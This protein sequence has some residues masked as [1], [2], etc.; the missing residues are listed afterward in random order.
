MVNIID[1]F[2]ARNFIQIDFAEIQTQLS[3]MSDILEYIKTNTNSITTSSISSKSTVGF[4][5]GDF[6]KEIICDLLIGWNENQWSY[7]I[8]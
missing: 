6:S 1:Q 4:M 7:T 8:T 2:S 3:T 5:R